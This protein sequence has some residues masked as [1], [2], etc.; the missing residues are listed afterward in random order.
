MFSVLQILSFCL[1]SGQATQLDKVYEGFELN[2]PV[3]FLKVKDI[4]V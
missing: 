2:L 3:G 1:Y 4:E